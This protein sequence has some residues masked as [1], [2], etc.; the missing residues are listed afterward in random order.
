M[1]IVL[2]RDLRT[3]HYQCLV[4]R[5]QRMRMRAPEDPSGMMEAYERSRNRLFEISKHCR[6]PLALA[7]R[8]REIGQ[9]R[10]LTC[11]S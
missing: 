1:C 6:G 3:V 5:E 2:G 7:L 8:D 9:S 10:L 4:C 11:S